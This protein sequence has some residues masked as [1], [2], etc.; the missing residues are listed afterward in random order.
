MK[1]HKT[2]QKT[3]QGLVKTEGSL[4]WKNA[5]AILEHSNSGETSINSRLTPP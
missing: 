5:A 1:N 3:E 2:F 4:V